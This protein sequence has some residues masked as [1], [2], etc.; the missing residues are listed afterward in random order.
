MQAATDPWID[1]VIRGYA[2]QTS[3]NRGGAIR[4]CISTT[5][6]SYQIE[7][8]R[9][10]WYGGAG[11]TL[12][13]TVSNLTGRQQPVPAPDPVTGMVAC[14]W[15]VSYTLQT[16]ATWVSGIYLAKLVAQSGAV[17][18]IPF[19][20]RADGVVADILY[21]VPVTTWQ[22]YN[23]WGGK[24]LYEFSSSGGQRAHKV[25]FDRPYAAWSGSGMLFDG[26]YNLV[27][28]L[29]REGY[30][31]TYCTNL[32]VQTS[33]TVLTGRKI[34]LSNFHDEYWS[35]PM[36]QRLKAA[37]DGGMHVAFL[38]SNNIY[39]Q[40]RFE[41]SAAGV[42]NRVMVCYKDA[43]LDPAAVTTPALTTVQ[44]R[45][46]P[47][48]DPE[49]ALLGVMYESYYTYGV[50]YPWIV[51]NADHWLY[52]GT[53]LTENQ[54][55]A[56][57]VGY[58]YD[59]VADNGKSPAGLTILSASPVVDVAGKSGISNGAMY[60]AASGAL[61]FC[62]GTNYWCWKLD[63]N[64]YQ[65]HGADTRIQRITTNLLTTMRSGLQLPAPLPDGTRQLYAETLSPGI[66]DWS[67]NATVNMAA[68]SPVYQGS[69][70]IAL[71]VTAAW[72]ALY[73]RAVSTMATTATTVLRFA[74]RAT[75]SGQRYA[76]ILYDLNNTRIGT[77]VWLA[78]HG[79]DPTPTGWKLYQIPLTAFGAAGLGIGGVVIQDGSGT[80]QPALFID[81]IALVPGTSVTPTPTPTPSPTPT[82]T[83]SVTATPTATAPAGT[84]L[85]V[86]G[87]ALASGWQN[88]SWN[89]TLNLQTTSPVYQGSAAI[90]LTV[91]AAWGALYLHAE[92][93]VVG[94]ASGS[95]RFAA[96]AS[97]SGQRYAVILYDVNNTRIGVPV[98]LADHG[99]DPLTGGW[100]TYQI[101][102]TALAAVGGQ[103][104]GIVLQDAA[105]TS[106][107]VV[108]IDDLRIG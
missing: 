81:D 39:W 85:L 33:T 100:K 72:G 30:D 14:A 10:G 68:A 53:G 27:R 20:V 92:T 65:N 2:D 108:Y 12:V 21:Q 66:Q 46:A 56:G 50:T 74:A 3:V 95:I 91:T 94:S 37:R 35:Q 29:E 102:L 107:P 99:G 62:A 82:A 1:T 9:I 69:N 51:K 48:S 4:F 67:W 71:T 11:A 13:Q 18:Y 45:E 17:G 22:A 59:R 98:L 55:I 40:V 57:V 23:N 106:Q 44:F 86:Y 89:A 26:D 24:S 38:D 16:G 78:N 103:I 43:A 79:G 105:G 64:E 41:P 28:W 88:W 25:S 96:R 63:D 49:N 61:V 36:R 83:P 19:V 80:A 87:D 97:Q 75:Q 42:T 76:V 101:P 7:V 60:T 15:Q 31:V 54:A 8:Y 70:A 77:P 90:A 6:P 47:V 58:E 5:E 73:L 52:A 32:D 93:P 104:G 84:G 34:F